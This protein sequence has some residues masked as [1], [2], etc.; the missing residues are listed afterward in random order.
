MRFSGRR[1]G[2]VP[3]SLALRDVH[4]CCE[5]M[6]SIVVRAARNYVRYFVSLDDTNA[7]VAETAFHTM[8]CLC[9]CLHSEHYYGPSTDCCVKKKNSKDALSTRLEIKL[10]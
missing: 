1:A 8:P 9:L 6:L 7:C 5:I 4:M 10:K 2:I 3:T